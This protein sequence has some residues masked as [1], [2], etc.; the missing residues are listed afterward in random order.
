MVNVDLNLKVGETERVGV[1]LL[2]TLQ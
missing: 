2:H 1:P